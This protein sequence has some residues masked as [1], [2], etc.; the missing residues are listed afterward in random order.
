MFYTIP[1]DI[2][3][4]GA[5]APIELFSKTITVQMAVSLPVQ[6]QKSNTSAG[7]TSDFTLCQ[8]MQASY[9]SYKTCKNQIGL[10]TIEK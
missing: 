1:R 6:N 7:A 8:W 9:L 10:L 4:S 3:I 5:L 2:R